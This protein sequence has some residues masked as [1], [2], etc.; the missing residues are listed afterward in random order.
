MSAGP[1]V[2]S[3]TTNVVVRAAR[4]VDAACVAV[5]CTQV[6]L[7]TYATDGIRPLLVREVASHFS[8]VAVEGF[9]AADRTRC[10][11][12]ER[13]GHLIGFAQMTIGAAHAA[14]PSTVPVEVERLYVLRHFAGQSVGRA[15]LAACEAVA[16]AHGATTVWLMAWVHNARALAFY[17]HRGYDDVGSDWYVFEHERH[18]NRVFRKDLAIR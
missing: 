12:A 5:L 1:P 7:D 15:L 14:V 16:V 11:V 17:A 9:L 10:L 6:Y 3:L 2:S 4:L 18:E 8:L 13:D